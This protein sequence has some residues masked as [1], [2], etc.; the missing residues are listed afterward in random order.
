M[1]TAPSPNERE[2]RHSEAWLAAE[3]EDARILQRLSASLIPERQPEALYLQILEAA[4]ELM[5]SDA[6][7][8]QMLDPDGVHLNLLAARNFHPI[9]H[10]FWQKVEADCNSICGQALGANTRIVVSD[11]EG[12]DFIGAG[13]LHEYRRNGI[14]GVQSS[15][16]LSRSGRPLGVISTHW[17]EVHEPSEREFALFD[18]LARQAADLIERTQVEVALRETQKR[19]ERVLETDAV[20]VLFFD[21]TGNVIHTN[22]VFLNMTGYS[23]DDV[24]QRELHWRNL[25][26]PE[27][28]KISEEQM[29]ILAKT[30]RIGPY[31][32]EYILKDGSRRWMLFAGRELGD[33]TISE[34]CIDITDRKRTQEA[35]LE[36]EERLRLFLE[37]VREYALVQ[38]DT[39]DRV[40]I[41][42]SGAERIF[43]YTPHEVLGRSFSA[44]FAPRNQDAA[45]H[46]T[47][48]SSSMCAGRHEDAH[49]FVHKDGSRIWTRWFTEPIRNQSGEIAAFAMVLRDETERLKTEAALRQTEK[50]AAVGRLASSIA[51]E[52]NNPLEAITNLVY[53]A[54]QETVSP[55]VANYL[56]LAQ[57]ELARVTQI[58]TETLRFHRQAG[59]PTQYDIIDIIESVLLLH[60]GRIR[61]AQITTERRY[62]RHP[63]VLC[64]A[65]EIRQ[66]VANL[67]GNAIDAM[68][69]NDD[70]RHLILR[71]RRA[72][73][74]QTGVVGVHFAISDTGT[75]IPE[76][77]KSH[78]FEPFFTTK[79]ITGTGL[80]LW[81]SAEIVRKHCGRLRFRSRTSSIYKGTTFS[82]F[83]S[84]IKKD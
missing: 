13:Q 26:P 2:I 53:L 27:W 39:N 3:L 16:L 37:N 36:S 25:T 46:A 55:T 84:D 77:S 76:S 32:K 68:S 15:P 42:N 79:A 58:A 5:H 62:D 52:I 83:L 1:P 10:D 41:W 64:L 56:E 31:E 24:E 21:S 66:V 9:S 6:S 57:H 17:R 73:N 28:V 54:H 81:I 8:L 59:G 45:V 44:L 38:T 78:I 72:V 11:V 33:G 43:G 20:G 23:R 67:V 65:N 71:V 34:Y 69:S 29:Q 61:A 75:G 22:D 49:W 19:L 50:L 70:A 12:C 51:H 35:L 47:E 4:M 80:G 82:M 7:S 14:R 18:V 74:P 60:E 40:T 30:G 48:V 63:T